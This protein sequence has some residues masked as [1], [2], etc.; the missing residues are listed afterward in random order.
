LLIPFLDILDISFVFASVI[1][2]PY[3]FSFTTF[4]N[5]FKILSILYK[6]LFWILITSSD[7]MYFLVNCWNKDLEIVSCCLIIKLSK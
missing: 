7:W 3:S 1:H 4:F 5:P 6:C 2:L